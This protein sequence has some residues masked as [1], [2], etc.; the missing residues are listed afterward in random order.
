M[1]TKTEETR[2]VQAESHRKAR[3]SGG[4]ATGVALKLGMDLGT[5][6]SVFQA[7][8]NGQPVTF[9]KDTDLV[10]SLV[11]FPKP[12][13][14]PGILPADA[15]VLFGNEAVEYRL[16][17]DLRWPMKDGF[18]DDMELGKLFTQHMHSIIDPSGQRELWG[19][20]GAP[21]NASPERQKDIR[22]VMVDVLDKILIVPEPFLA[23]MGLR[24]DP[25]FK[26][27]GI[28]IDPTK[29][30]LIV[31]IGAGT[32]DL[33][34]VRGYYPTAQDQISFPKAG[35]FIDEMLLK[36]IQRRYPDIKLTRVTVTQLKEKHSY[37][38]EEVKPINVKVYV[39][40][41]PRQVDFGEIIR[42]A[43]D[44]LVPDI[45]AGIKE[46]LARCDSDSVECILK[47]I[48]VTG[49]GSDIRG[50]CERLQKALR[51]DGY[52]VATTRKP[53][54]Y[55]RLVSRGAL[56]VAENV[57]DDQWQVPF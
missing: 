41:R 18:V 40:G 33:C 6:T 47:N 16:H 19:V 37:L 22:S 26:D 55:K 34:L 11:G 52:D 50:I 35:N 28:E 42:E 1:T 53:A 31:D 5:N 20:I 44:A 57:R 3:A 25:G 46:L 2:S 15:K 8:E 38:S 27:K 9:E 14:I 24:E 12:G 29:H 30:S 23:A 4:S 54:D 51:E 21:A 43:C 32:T 13:I 10:L 17:L 56:K 45:L 48:I 36:G 39:D 49:G 7:S